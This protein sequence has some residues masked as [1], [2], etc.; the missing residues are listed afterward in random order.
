MKNIVWILSLLSKF[1]SP[2]QSLENLCQST[3]GLKKKAKATGKQK[4]VK[5]KP[6][7][8]QKDEEDQSLALFE[9]SIPTAQNGWVF[10]L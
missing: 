1:F 3:M 6:K 9:S 10:T 5:G 7:L 8:S 2:I 4:M